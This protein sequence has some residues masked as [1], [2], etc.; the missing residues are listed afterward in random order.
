[1]AIRK[2]PDRLY[3]FALILGTKFR[4]NYPKVLA[5]H[6]EKDVWEILLK[7]EKGENEKVFFQS[8]K[9]ADRFIS[10]RRKSFGNQL[11]KYGLMPEIIKYPA[12]VIDVGANIGEFLLNFES[13]SDL[14]LIGFEPDDS[15]MRCLERND[16]FSRIT[17]YPL[18]ASNSNG[19]I[20]F[21]LSTKDADSST[22]EPEVWTSKVRRDRIRLDD[23]IL[24][25]LSSECNLYL[26]ID[27]EG[28]E[29][30]VLDGLMRIDRKLL[31][32]ISIDVGPERNGMR[33]EELCRELLL[34]LG[35]NEVS[36]VSENILVAAKFED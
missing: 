28:G 12:A 4:P 30:E 26:K 15:A 10:G 22:F 24:K 35:F 16:V 19:F 7:N 14:H 20:D 3:C 23:W 6:F 9:R 27:A 31:R 21:Y 8:L 13:L 17:K 1:M 33:T 2:L 34:E 18:V 36:L 11:S 29:P 32:F 25:N 5:I